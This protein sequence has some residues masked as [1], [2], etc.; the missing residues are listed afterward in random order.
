MSNNKITL[1]TLLAGFGLTINAV[2]A[3]EVCKQKDTDK[4]G[5]VTLAENEICCCKPKVEGSNEF[6]CEPLVKEDGKCPPERETKVSI[7]IN[8]QRICVCEYTKK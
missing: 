3:G 2:F 8:N 1:L 5:K 7:K 4:D 6:E